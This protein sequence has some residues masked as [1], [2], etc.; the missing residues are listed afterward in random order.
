MKRRIFI[1]TGIGAV[2]AGCRQKKVIQPDQSFTVD[3]LTGQYRKGEV[4]VDAVLDHYLGRIKLLDD[5]GPRLR[6]VVELNPAMREYTH[7]GPLEGVPIFIKDN[8]ETADKMETTAGSLALLGA[9]KPGRD[10]HVVQRLRES[11]AVIFGKTN[12]SEWANIRSPNSSSG[13]SARGGLTVNPHNTAYSASG[14]SSGSAVAVAA[15]FCPAAIGT[16]TN[17]SIVSPASACGIVGLK[18]T[19]GLVSR[20]GIIPITR[21]QDTAGPMTQ[22]VRDAA[23]L[24]NVLAGKDERDT[25][26]QQA[27]IEADYTF[28]LA[29]ATFKGI[30]IG[31]LNSMSGTH[32]GVQRLFKSQLEK[33]KEAGAIIVEDVSIPNHPEASSA[34]WVAMLTELRQEMNQYLGSRHSAVKSLAELIEYNK[35]FRESEM[36]HF[37]QEFF[38]DAESRHTPEHVEKAVETRRLARRLSGPE[39]LDVALQKHDLDVLI[40]PTNDPTGRID[41]DLGDARVRI[42]GSSAAV[43]GYPHLTVP[44]GM[45]NDLPIGLSFVGAAWSENLLLRLGQ[46]FENIREFTPPKLYV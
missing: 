33:L 11:G 12:L 28:G 23:L 41:L 16:E 6:A 46:A 22:T 21:W 45:V 3:A 42:F 34:A 19:L 26:T 32:K 1:G 30:R 10:A 38:V 35:E 15:G 37:N 43:A 18:P 17:G 25:M 4:T 39:G 5:D 8:I 29:D 2:L 9:Q 13:W 40:C 24:L 7:K 14:S 20:A 36:A 27:K 44:M 31:V